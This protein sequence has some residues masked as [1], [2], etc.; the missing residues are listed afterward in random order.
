KGLIPTIVQDE[1]KQVLM[2]AFSSKDSLLKTFRTRRATYY[3]RSRKNIWTKG[4]T[5]GNFQEIIKVRYDC[6]RDTLLFTI[7]QKNAACHLGNYSCFG[8]GDKEFCLDKLYDVIQDRIKNPKENSYT[9]KI[10]KDEELIKKKIREESEE[11]LNYKDRNNLVWELADLTY[12]LL[13]LMAKK[14]I[15]IN[16]VKSELW[17]RRK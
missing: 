7:R 11:V 16:D 14:G 12:F 13:V 4:E 9:S 8:D 2:L 6:D 3:S 10:S 1:R 15:T 17:R 5:S